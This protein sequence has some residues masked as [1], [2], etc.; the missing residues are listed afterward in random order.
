MRLGDDD[1]YSWYDTYLV[2]YQYTTPEL[3]QAVRALR[4]LGPEYTVRDAEADSADG[5]ASLIVDV[6]RL[7]V[8]VEV[9]HVGTFDP[10]F[11]QKLVFAISQQPQDDED[12]TKLFRLQRCQYYYEVLGYVQ[13]SEDEDDETVGTGEETDCLV[14]MEAVSGVIERITEGVVVD[15]QKSEFV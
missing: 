10:D 7:R 4:A 3:E 2:W 1:R 12:V 8:A 6:P 14:A 15:P 11:R 13:L 9:A 5:L